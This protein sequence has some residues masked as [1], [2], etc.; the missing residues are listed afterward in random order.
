MPEGDT[1]H[2]LAGYLAPRL[3]GRSLVGGRLAGDST[4]E[5]RGLRVDR[6]YARGKHLCLELGEELVRTH[7]GMHGAW[8][9]Y[10]PGERWKRPE[11]H[12]SLVLETEEDVFVCFHA[13]E[14]ERV[15]LRG[16]R[17]RR[18]DERLG[19]D[20]AGTTTPD[21]HELVRRARRR[22]PQSLFADLL[23]DQ[24]VAAGVGNVYK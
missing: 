8:H 14:A 24:T 5:W 3:E 10:R 16:P 6:V 2:K 18:L 7:L 21:F 22:G 12:A 23:L 13:R 4:L 15:A 20:L 11:H 9:R 17:A 19:P 1:L